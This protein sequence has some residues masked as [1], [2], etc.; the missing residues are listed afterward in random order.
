MTENHPNLI[1]VEDAGRWIGH[2]FHFNES[3]VAVGD[4]V[5]IAKSICVPPDSLEEGITR[6]DVISALLNPIGPITTERIEPDQE[7][8]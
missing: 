8:P 6:D 3:L 2:T 7:N 5:M 4:G 1:K